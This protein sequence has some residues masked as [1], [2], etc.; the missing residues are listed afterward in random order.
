VRRVR[1]WPDLQR[2]AA[3]IQSNV[4]VPGRLGETFPLHGSA[5]WL[6]GRTVNKIPSKLFLFTQVEIPLSP[7]FGRLHLPDWMS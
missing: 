3:P 1:L 5:V 2:N 7:T 6:A 4:L